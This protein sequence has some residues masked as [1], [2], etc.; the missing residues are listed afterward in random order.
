MSQQDYR[1]ERVRAWI[2]VQA[3]P[4][5]EVAQV[6][7]ER[8]GHEG[9]DSFVIVRANVVDH[10][11]YNVIVPVDAESRGVL[12]EVRA[13]IED[14]PGVGGTQIIAVVPDG[15]VPWPPHNAHGYITPR[16]HEAGDDPK[17]DIGRF[18]QSPGFNAWG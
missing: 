9:G 3:A 11:P 16:E 5:E 18:P 1:N 4:A 7:Y 12:E 14:L 8:L 13:M 15:Q 2:F 17:A 6:L 10:S